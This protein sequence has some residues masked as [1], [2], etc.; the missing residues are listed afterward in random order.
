MPN[1]C[2]SHKNNKNVIIP[3]LQ[4]KMIRRK[5]VN[6]TINSRLETYI[7]LSTLYNHDFK[8]RLQI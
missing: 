2:I 6:V 4:K 1:L 3:T 7:P 5:R 8:S